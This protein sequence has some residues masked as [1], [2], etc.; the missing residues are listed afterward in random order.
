MGLYRATYL[1][2]LISTSPETTKISEMVEAT[3]TEEVITFI[4]NKHSK[5]LSKILS[6]SQLK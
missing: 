5:D 4:R 1:V 2:V 6:V 3:N